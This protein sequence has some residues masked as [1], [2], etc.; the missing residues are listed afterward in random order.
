SVRN[1]EVD[2]SVRAYAAMASAFKAGD[3]PEFNRQLATYRSKLAPNLSRE[4]SKAHW[5]MFFNHMQPFYNAIVIYVLAGLLVL[6]FWINLWE[7]LRRSAV[8]LIVVGLLIHTSGL[9]FRMALEGR[10]PVTNLYSS[11]IFI[12]FGAVVLGLVL[13]QFHRNGIGAIVAA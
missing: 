1:G 2:P 6:C 3:A 4:L 5:E 7:T 13:E 10:P 11:A 8:W 12:G 9:I